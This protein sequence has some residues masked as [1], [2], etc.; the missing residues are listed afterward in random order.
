MSPN[1]SLVISLSKS[2]S[3]RA[4]ASCLSA[5]SS[6]LASSSLSS[7]SSL[8]S[9]PPFAPSDDDPARDDAGDSGRSSGDRALFEPCRVSVDDDET[10]FVGRGYGNPV[11]GFALSGL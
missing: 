10:F 8:V 5:S 11:A 2:A 3:F 7:S 9:S 1:A 6:L 4:S